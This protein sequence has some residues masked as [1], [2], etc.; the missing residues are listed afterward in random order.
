M[1]YVYLWLKS[2]H[3][4]LVGRFDIDMMHILHQNTE[5]LHQCIHSKLDSCWT[6]FMRAAYCLLCLHLSPSQLQSHAQIHRTY[7]PLNFLICIVSQE[8]VSDASCL[9]CKWIPLS[10]EG[11]HNHTESKHWHHHR[12]SKKI[13]L[14]TL[15]YPGLLI[16][17]HSLVCWNFPFHLSISVFTFEKI[18]FVHIRA[19]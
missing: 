13:Q 9:E 18:P 14:S 12:C 15:N 3:T 17:C 4:W 11:Q 19:L 5:S 16:V 1:F 2:T 6:D 7:A 10:Y 8:S